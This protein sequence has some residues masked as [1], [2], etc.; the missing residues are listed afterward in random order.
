MR[1]LGDYVEGSFV[2]KYRGGVYP[3]WRAVSLEQNKLKFLIGHVIP[4]TSPKRLQKKP[5]LR[6]IQSS[7]R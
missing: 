2:I 1:E 5:I 6:P 4:V 3:T 7:S